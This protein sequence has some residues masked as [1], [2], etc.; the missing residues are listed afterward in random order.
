MIQKCPKCGVWFSAMRTDVVKRAVDGYKK[1]G[2][3]GA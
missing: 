1:A 3:F 2:E